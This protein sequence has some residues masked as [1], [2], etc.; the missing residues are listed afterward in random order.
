MYIE[1]KMDDRERSMLRNGPINVNTHMDN[2][3]NQPSKDHQTLLMYIPEHSCPP[4][5]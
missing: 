1:N 3:E 5:L 4:E 2:I